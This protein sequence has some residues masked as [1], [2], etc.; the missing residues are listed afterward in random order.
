MAAVLRRAYNAQRGLFRATF[1][2]T[3]PKFRQSITD[4]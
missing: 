3:R 1:S 4:K 2:G